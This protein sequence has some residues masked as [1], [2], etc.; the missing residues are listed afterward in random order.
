MRRPMSRSNRATLAQG[1]QFPPKIEA[2]ARTRKSC[3]QGI[4]EMLCQ[5]PHHDL[6]D[7][8]RLSRRGRKHSALA[9]LTKCKVPFWI[10]HDRLSFSWKIKQKLATRII[11]LRSREEKPWLGQFEGRSCGYVCST[12]LL[13]PNSK[14]LCYF[15]K[16][17]G[18]L[19]IQSYLVV[20]M[21]N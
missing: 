20:L 16:Y 9:G 21:G 10:L 3:S 12:I 8:D 14:C 2:K 18:E 19:M 5:S 13:S 6:H 17:P 4:I 11:Y 7:L 1:Q 15:I